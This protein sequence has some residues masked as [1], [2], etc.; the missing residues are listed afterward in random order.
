MSYRIRR[1]PT[2]AG[3]EPSGVEATTSYMSGGMSRPLALA[4]IVLFALAVPYFLLRLLLVSIYT[5]PDIKLSPDLRVE[6][7]AFSRLEAKGLAEGD[8]LAAVNGVPVAD[9]AAY[10]RQLRARRGRWVGLTIVPASEP[11]IP[12][13][14]VWAEQRSLPVLNLAEGL[15]LQASEGVRLE[16][17][18]LAAGDQLLA[19]NGAPVAT[20]EAAA[21]PL[22]RNVG[23]VRLTFARPSQSP[24]PWDL[25]IFRL[26][27][28]VAWALFVAGLTF[29]VL[30]CVAFGLRPHTRSSWG[31][32]TFCLWV[33]ALWFLRAVPTPFR[34]AV[35]K[36]AYLLFQSFSLAPF[37]VFLGTF[38]PLRF[39]P[40]RLPAIVTGAAIFGLILW[41]G[42]WII[43]PGRAAEGILAR[44][45]FTL[46]GLASL[47][48]TLF[49][50]PLDAWYR[51]R[52]VPLGAVDRQRMWVVRV[53]VLLAFLPSALYALWLAR[54]G[55]NVDIRP[56]LELTPLLFPLLIAY[57]I[58]RHNLLQLGEMVREGLLYGVLL[59]F[60]GAAHSALAASVG[61]L[62]EHLLAVDS[63][64]ISAAMVGV[65]VLGGIPVHN[66]L[67]QSIHTRFG[68]RS[69]QDDHERFLDTI[70]E[71][72]RSRTSPRA[73]LKEFAARVGREIDAESVAILLRHPATAQWW[74]ATATA[75]LGTGPTTQACAPLFDLLAT[76]RREIHR[77][78]LIED[79]R[80]AEVG[81]ACLRGMTALRAE[82]ILPLNLGGELWGALAVGSKR[83]PQ[84]FT[85]EEIR[86]LGRLAKEC[87]VGLYSCFNGAARPEALTGARII[88]LFPKFPPTI[89]R[90]RVE[91][92]IG[93]GGMAYVYRGRNTNGPVAIKVANHKVQADPKLM[94]RFRH[95]CQA[96]AR[97]DH[98]HIVRLIEVGQE[99][100]EPYAVFEFISG[101]SLGDRLLRKGRLGVGEA[102]RLAREIAEGLAAALEAG[103]V[104]RDIKP[105]NI[106]LTPEGSAKVSD[107][108]LARL[109][110]ATTLTTHPQM[111]GTPAY[112]SPEAWQGGRVDWRSDQYALGVVFYE[113]LTGRRPFKGS[114]VGAIAYQHIN[115]PVPD[116]R[117]VLPETGDQVAEVIRRMLAK[118]P[119]DRFAS[120][121][122]LLEAFSPTLVGAAVP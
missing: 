43:A 67:R 94:H 26:D 5:Y 62:L 122:E 101:G 117:S 86:L 112:L 64:W 7:G 28:R 103:I 37:V 98:P 17:F 18:D 72:T 71:L 21:E 29:G 36:Q 102:Q 42:N 96:L 78:E 118:R 114:T 55:A 13:R 63:G 39:R 88:D 4:A 8:R 113:L 19:V 24:E 99:G 106:L 58:V 51:I 32:L 121:A 79:L 65:I 89:G 44:P 56:W 75:P 23:L 69:Q 34:F 91:A 81:P 108:G 1:H 73:F 97:L 41:L 104:H 2:D 47:A 27:W 74:L 92:V 60:V 95:E 85:P 70:Y 50:L 40:R 66:K 119:E 77:E 16:D 3:A 11:A 53:A 46:W 30:G 76:L 80:F 68:R 25:V 38:S 33:A 6:A 52:G 12:R 105:G 14:L 111:A 83:R 82:I 109:E 116:V 20:P 93:H 54:G 90:Y 107:F 49:V 48:A 84:N 115:A 110:E 57:A 10:R 61:P 31:F 59:V 100:P 35:E 87:A 120:Y 9:R 22:R 45:L 15:I